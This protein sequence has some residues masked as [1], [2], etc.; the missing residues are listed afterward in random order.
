MNDKKIYIENCKKQWQEIKRKNYPVNSFMIS[1]SSIVLSLFALGGYKLKQKY[2][3]PALKYFWY[4]LLFTLF[5]SF[6]RTIPNLHNM[7]T[8]DREYLKEDPIV[9]DMTQEV[10]AQKLKENIDDKTLYIM[11]HGTLGLTRSDAILGTF[12]IDFEKSTFEEKKFSLDKNSIVN[13]VLH[14]DWSGRLSLEARLYAQKLLLEKIDK[15]YQQYIINDHITKFALF[16]HSYGGEN[17]LR[18]GLE[19]QKKYNKPVDLFLIS[20]PLSHETADEVDQFL[21]N[22]KNI[23]ENDTKNTVTIIHSM[24][25]W[26]IAADPTKVR[27]NLPF[28]AKIICVGQPVN[29]QMFYQK[30]YQKYK[31]D[32]RVK[33]IMYG[34]FPKEPSQESHGGHI[35]VVDACGFYMLSSRSENRIQ[36]LQTYLTMTKC[37]KESSL[38]RMYV[39][40]LDAIK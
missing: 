9:V 22:N 2:K 35:S 39:N 32:T 21:E 19:L 34:V 7:V 28:W 33:F 30:Y 1:A 5:K 23:P 14:M 3:H 26:W 12:G 15:E 37:S 29:D 8:R 38:N 20:T 6:F 27:K 24:H 17:V 11:C 40:P 25:D 10:N 16:G 4:F 31:N 18:V 36:A 13:N